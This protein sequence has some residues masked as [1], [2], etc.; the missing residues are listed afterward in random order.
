MSYCYAGFP[1]FTKWGQEDI[2]F[3]TTVIE[4][5]LRIFRVTDPGL[6]H[7]YHEKICGPSAD[8]GCFM[9]Q[10]HLEGN[11]RQL[12]LKYFQQLTKLDGLNI[13]GA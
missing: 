4:S 8:P 10:A 13:G 2:H 3:H 7:V 5:K 11:Q 12:G 9:S 6:D 1:E